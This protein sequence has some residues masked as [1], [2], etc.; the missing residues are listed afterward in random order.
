VRKKISPDVAVARAKKASLTRCVNNGERLP[1]D[2]EL[3]A[4]D[5]DLVAARIGSYIERQLAKAPELTDKQRN[6]LAELLRPVR[7]TG[8]GAA[9]AAEQI[10]AS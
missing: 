10:E 4:A 1:D 5:R 6:D 9:V 8:S 3:A 7:V 2:P